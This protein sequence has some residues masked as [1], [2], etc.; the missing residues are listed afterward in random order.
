MSISSLF[1]RLAHRHDARQASPTADAASPAGSP[2]PSHRNGV[3][4][5]RGQRLQA[6]LAQPRTAPAGQPQAPTRE[7]RLLT[8]TGHALP[9]FWTEPPAAH[10]GP[11]TAAALPG[12]MVMSAQHSG[13]PKDVD[14]LMGAMIKANVGMVLDL[15][16]S[17]PACVKAPP[18]FRS[19]N[20][21]NKQT[22]FTVSNTREDVKQHSNLG[23]VQLQTCNWGRARWMQVPRP[24]ASELAPELAISGLR[25]RL[26]FKRKA[27]K[28]FIPQLERQQMTLLHARVNDAPA[29]LSPERLQG[30]LAF[31]DK[32]RQSTPG[33][34]VAFMDG[35][36][37]G[38]ALQLAVAER[39]RRVIKPN[40]DA[41]AVDQAVVQTYAQVAAG[42]PKRS[43]PPDPATLASLAAFGDELVRAQAGVPASPPKPPRQPQLRLAAAQ[44]ART[45]LQPPQQARAEAL[46]QPPLRHAVR[47][48]PQ[49]PRAVVAPM[50][51]P[52]S[53]PG[54]LTA[55]ATANRKR[56]VPPPKP[57]TRTLQTGSS[58]PAGQTAP[59][60]GTQQTGQPE[61]L[62]RRVSMR[63]A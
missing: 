30:M 45:P 59:Q 42:G 37:D 4:E 21:K 38:P 28:P 49:L 8:D 33:L 55:P 48:Q 3:D 27:D 62:P 29:V 11:G 23:D 32:Q 13:R 26:G 15:T 20:V 35:R 36:G 12:F 5:Q 34:T 10:A 52:P 1:N 44:Q 40:M 58:D 46:A 24:L 18:L 2:S 22:W 16:A 41:A 6:L 53:A 63:Q 17:D 9:A 56:P 43:G 50:P 60:S 47:S 61:P 14:E 54:D 7:T 31:C 51:R 57:L 19:Q 39:L 25:S